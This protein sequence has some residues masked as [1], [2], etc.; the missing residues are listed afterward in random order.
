MVDIGLDI[1][2]ACTGVCVLA[3]DG[4]LL[5]LQ[6][7]KLSHLDGLW[8][9]ADE[10]RSV[11]SGVHRDLGST[12]VRHIFVE[13]NLQMFRRGLSS[14]KTLTTL[15][16]FN[17]VVS[18]VAREIFSVEPISINVNHGR[19]AVGLKLDRKDK[20]R[21]TKQQVLDWVQDQLAEVAYPWPTKTLKSGPRKGITILEPGCFDMADAYVT[22]RAGQVSCT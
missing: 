8:K 4:T 17:G 22:C 7:V 15:S 19:K 10:I 1:S 6:F 13:E 3:E 21:N 20:E 16:R 9:K 2:T 11:L 12:Q 14:A 18:Y 5:E